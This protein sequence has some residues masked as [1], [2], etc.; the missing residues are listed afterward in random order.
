MALWAPGRVRAEGQGS[1]LSALRNFFFVTEAI[2]SGKHGPYV[3]SPA[4]FSSPSLHLLWWQATSLASC[5]PGAWNS[6]PALAHRLSGSLHQALISHLASF[7]AFLFQL[8]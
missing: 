8:A 1:W 2:I 3:G 6:V 5:H 7:S 4:G